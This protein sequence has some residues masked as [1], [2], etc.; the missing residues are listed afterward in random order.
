QKSSSIHRFIEK[1]GENI[2]EGK[3]CAIESLTTRHG[4]YSEI[5]IADSNGNYSI[6]RLI[7]DPFSQ[8]LYTTKAEEFAEIKKLQKQ[9]L[10]IVEAISRVAGN[11][12]KG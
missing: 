5:M 7:L 8:M 6:G 2:D 3:K 1:Q 11:L 10:S 12:K 9:G 4:E